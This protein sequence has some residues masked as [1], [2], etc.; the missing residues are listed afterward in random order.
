MTDTIT[1]PRWQ[2]DHEIGN[3]LDY[4]P[5]RE[6]RRERGE[7]K[8]AVTRVYYSRIPEGAM[9][10]EE[11]VAHPEPASWERTESTAVYPMTLA[12]GTQVYTVLRDDV[13]RTEWKQQ[14][15]MRGGPDPYDQ[16][17]R[18]CDSGPGSGWTYRTVSD[19]LA[20]AKDEAETQA[21]RER[22]DQLEE[23]A[24][25]AAEFVPD[26]R[27]RKTLTRAGYEAACTA[28]GLVPCPDDVI[29]SKNYSLTHGN[30]DLHSYTVE[31]GV[32]MEL[33][34]ARMRGQELERTQ[35]DRDALQAAIAVVG[36]T[37]PLGREEYEAGCRAAG[38]P[39]LPDRAVDEADYSATAMA[40]S[41][42]VDLGHALAVERMLGSCPD[43]VRHLAGR[44][45]VA[46]DNEL[47]QQRQAE[48]A[49]LPASHE[50]A[51][52]T[53]VDEIERLLGRRDEGG[54]FFL[55]PTDRA[56]IENLSKEAAGRYITSLRGNY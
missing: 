33:T 42:V 10:G 45:A 26:E 12:D 3:H 35:A 53:Q 2:P 25:A 49:A 16:Y 18:T 37:G 56:G 46:L 8:S 55:G 27:G 32:W 22:R 51:T 28:I 23:T 30:F 47:R 36:P 7:G 52:A 48:R 4:L 24:G 13:P 21:R 19:A 43:T 31:H 11:P 14:G 41:G 17:R 1:A 39:A 34:L 20:G 29:P 5:E 40:A 38:V 6:I 44:R 50:F 15:G 9:V 54:G